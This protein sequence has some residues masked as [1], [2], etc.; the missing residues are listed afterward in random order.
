MENQEKIRVEFTD[1]TSESKYKKGDTGFVDGYYF[2]TV[3]SSV[4]CIVVLDKNNSFVSTCLSFKI[5]PI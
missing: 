4:R 2:D 5:Q 1:S 3:F